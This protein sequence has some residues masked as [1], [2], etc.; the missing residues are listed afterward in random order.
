M[1][2]PPKLN[3]NR[4]MLALLLSIVI[5]VGVIQGASPILSPVQPEGTSMVTGGIEPCAGLI[6]G[7]LPY[8]PGTVTV[9]R[10]HLGWTAEIQGV[11]HVVLPRDLV[12]TERL[13]GDQPFVFYLEP[14]SYVLVVG[15]P[16]KSPRAMEITVTSANWMRADIPSGCL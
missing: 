15:D 11:F 9:Y 1:E 16:A 5:A 10:G 6:E 4:A 7:T 3:P 14:G 2:R 8:V 13:G 12:A